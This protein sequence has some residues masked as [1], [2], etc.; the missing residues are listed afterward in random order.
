M[1][2]PLDGVWVWAKPYS[3]GALGVEAEALE[4]LQEEEE[5]IWKEQVRFL[6]T[7][8]SQ[9]LEKVKCEKR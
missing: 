2:L 4:Q 7:N 6:V 5:Q 3:E 1:T 8:W 9:T